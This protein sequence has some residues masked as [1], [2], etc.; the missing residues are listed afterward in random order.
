MPQQ[1]VLESDPLL[2]LPTPPSVAGSRDWDPMVLKPVQGVP[3]HSYWP[4]CLGSGALCM[5]LEEVQ[6][7][8]AA[9]V[10]VAVM[11]HGDLPHVPSPPMTPPSLPLPPS[12]PSPVV[13]PDAGTL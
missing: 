9:V 7:H 5:S 1:H 12:P 3:P 10:G 2:S 4:P 8:P 6:P 11:A 13:A